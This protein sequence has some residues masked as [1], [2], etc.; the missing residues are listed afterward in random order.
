MAESYPSQ[1]IT[2]A[3]ILTLVAV[4]GLAGNGLTIIS[5]FLST[6]LQTKTNVFVV[7]LAVGD[8]ITCTGILVQLVALFSRGEPFIPASFG[9]LIAILGSVSMS[10]T[11]LT[12]AMIG[13]IRCT[14]AIRSP[15]IFDRL[16]S[17]LKLTLMVFLTW[18]IP[19]S[20]N[21]LYYLGGGRNLYDSQIK[22]YKFALLENTGFDIPVAI[23]FVID[24]TLVIVCT[25]IM[26]ICYLKIV[27]H[28]RAHTRRISVELGGVSPSSQALESG[29]RAEPPLSHQAENSQQRSGRPA[30]PPLRFEVDLTLTWLQRQNLMY[31]IKQQIILKNTY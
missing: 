27:L 2:T 10:S 8:V 18:A 15:I 20:S 31:H 14:R 22:M 17:T 11:I 30:R 4:T 7:N 16:F 6:K 24:A 29:N 3:T 5:V 26:L 25:L 28:V 1:Y 23:F 19:V 21:V 9:D 12:L 13:I